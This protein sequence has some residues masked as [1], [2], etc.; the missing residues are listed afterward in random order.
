MGKKNNI[1]NLNSDEFKSGSWEVYHPNGKHM[2]TGGGKKAKWYL[3]RNLA[4]IIGEKKIK[5]TFK[6]EGYGFSED[7][8][9]GK[10]AREIK[11]VV[12][13]VNINLQKHHIV[14]YC[15]RT[16]FPDE[17]KSRNHHDVVLINSEKHAE[18]EIE[19]TKYKNDL[20][21]QYNVKTIEE[22]NKIYT[23][24]LRN[25]NKHN[26]ISINKLKAIL[27]GYNRISQQKIYENLMVVSENTEIDFNFLK[28]CNYIQI[29]KLYKLLDNDYKHNIQLFQNRHKKY[30]D[31]G[32]HLVSKLNTD[33]KL[34]EFIKIW[35]K[36]FI[37][38]MKPKHMPKGWSINFR[39][40]SKI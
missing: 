24:L 38:T 31:H 15:Y 25:V 33:K 32:Y 18:Y 8:E 11:C 5:L 39:Y 3:S 20:A 21:I 19:A 26:T 2:F 29:Y 9:F 10:T 28:K 7:E 4:T 12:T 36:H 14:P 35:R 6:P 13:G 17:Y 40:K 23:R 37:K 16:Y 34:E 27:N 22:Y 30:Y 1:L